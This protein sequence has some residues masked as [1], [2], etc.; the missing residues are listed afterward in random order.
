MGPESSLPLSQKLTIRSYAER[1]K[2]SS[3]T[4]YF[5]RCYFN[6]FSPS[7]PRSPKY[8]LLF[9]F[10]VQ[11]GQDLGTVYLCSARYMHC[12]SHPHAYSHP[13]KRSVWNEYKLW[14]S[15]LCIFLHPLVVTSL[16]SQNFLCALSPVTPWCES[17]R[18][19]SIQHNTIIVL[20]WPI[21]TL[22]RTLS[23]GIKD[24][25]F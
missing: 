25:D 2:F 14:S 22:I 3:Q 7:T 20:Y 17:A 18:L 8:F 12:L 5:I 11:F 6:N 21:A 10:Y 24:K 9:S 1:D 4:I 15:L 16:L 19:T 13:Y 23:G